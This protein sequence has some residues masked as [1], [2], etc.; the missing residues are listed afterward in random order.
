M[1]FF[2]LSV[3]SKVLHNLLKILWSQR[4]YQ[5]YKIP[6]RTN[7][8]FWLERTSVLSKLCGWWYWGNWIGRITTWRRAKKS[9]R[10]VDPSILIVILIIIIIPVTLRTH[11][12]S[13]RRIVKKIRLWGPSSLW[14]KPKASCW[15]GWL[16]ANEISECNMCA[17]AKTFTSVRTMW[18]T[19]DNNL[20]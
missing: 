8:K 4:P 1:A 19:Q 9:W 5:S 14:N 12:K 17:L 16:M 18:C 2:V 10:S 20:K 7:L 15:R 11:S 3:D 6:T 13:T